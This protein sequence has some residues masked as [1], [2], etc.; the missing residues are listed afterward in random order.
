MG[1]VE[2]DSRTLN[3]TIIAHG[4]L[5]ISNVVLSTTGYINEDVQLTYDV[6]NNGGTDA[7]RGYVAEDGQTISTVWNDSIDAGATESKSNILNFG[8][9]GDKS[10]VL[11]VGYVTP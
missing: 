2:T 4:D 9:P 3:I 7:C 11:Y 1:F 8:T 6:T 5:E 10:I